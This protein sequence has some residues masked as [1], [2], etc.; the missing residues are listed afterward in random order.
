VLTAPGARPNTARAM[1]VDVDTLCTRLPVTWTEADLAELERELS[2][3]GVMFQQHLVS[4]ASI[5][6]HIERSGSL[7]A[8]LTEL[9]DPHA[10]FREA[11][12]AGSGVGS[13]RFEAREYPDYW[14]TVH[15]GNA[16]REAYVPV[17]MLI[18][19]RSPMPLR[20]LTDLCARCTEAVGARVG[21]VM[22]LAWNLPRFSY[23]LHTDDE[24]E[25]VYSRVHLPLRTT[26][27][28]LFVWARDCEA[29]WG[30]WLRA[31]HLEQG[32]LYQVRTDVPHTVINGHPTEGRLHLI[33][34]VE[35]PFRARRRDA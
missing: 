22:F 5:P 33:L 12:Q 32:R 25:A 26:P 6:S 15:A 18:P 28:N 11:A 24:Y 23:D 30:D 7:Q 19:K 8:P 9:T 16:T 29:P 27:E 3:Y 4:H 1:H 34:D 2:P 31:T 20:K 17:V 14:M 13:V 21:G 10:L 35:G